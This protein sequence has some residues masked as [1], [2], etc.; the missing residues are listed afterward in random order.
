MYIYVRA[1]VVVILFGAFFW[2]MIG[3]IYILFLSLL[4]L[5]TR[6]YKSYHIDF[7]QVL[8]R[9]LSLDIQGYIL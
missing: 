1:W 2:S 6:D 4:I 8:L 5:G 3:C 9:Y 7:I